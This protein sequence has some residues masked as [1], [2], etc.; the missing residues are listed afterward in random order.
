MNFLSSRQKKDLKQIFMSADKNKKTARHP[1]RGNRTLKFFDRYA[2]IPLAMG[3]GLLRRKQPP[4]P[5]LD[6]RRAA[7]LQTAAIG[8]T[9][10]SSAVVQD[11]KKAWPHAEVTFFTGSSNYETAGLIPGIDSIIKLPIK[12]PLSARKLIR[13]AGPFDIWIDF[14]PWPRLN[15]VLSFFANAGI[16]VG[17]ETRDQYRHYVYDVTVKHSSH[18]HE[19]ENYRALLK[20]FGISDT[21]SAPMLNIE[22][23]P[24][25]A[26][27]IVV[28]MFPGGSRSF[29][30]EWPEHHWVALITTFADQ[31]YTIFLTGAPA[32]RERAAA[33]KDR[34]RGAEGVHVVAGSQTIRETAELLS[35]SQLT[36]SVDTGIMHVASAL[37]CNLISLHGPTSPERWGPLNSNAVP[38]QGGA[39]CSPCLSLGFESKCDDPKCMAALSVE[40]VYAAATRLL[41][42]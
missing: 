36:I 5:G 39:S 32:D 33:I 10:L 24:K 7:F 19:I 12:T 30:K 11:F 4:L 22:A 23:R 14:G 37:G 38:V 2:G 1:E 18:R 21:A 28:H 8:D 6:V 26:K 16:T 27:Q 35:A 20:G 13:Q 34:I 15:A 25:R 17:F 40:E 3:L 41:R 31:G 42:P 9:V 29:L